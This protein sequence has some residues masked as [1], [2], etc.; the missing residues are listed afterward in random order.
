MTGPA[1]YVEVC[2]SFDEAG[3][4]TSLVWVPYSGSSF[5]A[6]SIPDAQVIGLSI[7]L[8]WAVAYTFKLAKRALDL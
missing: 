2:T 8:V 6:L 4:C 7:A 1:T 3:A 5:P